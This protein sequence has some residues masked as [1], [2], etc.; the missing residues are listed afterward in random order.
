MSA[1]PT[2]LAL[3]PWL[4]STCSGFKIEPLGVFR[5]DGQARWPIT[6]QN[7]DD[8]HRQLVAGRFLAPLPKEPASLANVVEVAVVDFLVQQLQTISGATYARGSERGYPDL[9]ICG[10]A[11]GG[12]FH[13]VDVKVA[14]R[15]KNK[16][17]TQSA[18]TLYTGNT[19]FKYP[20]LHWPGTFRPFDEY[21]THVD[22]IAIY[23]FNEKLASR[24]ED[25]ELIV[26]EPWRIASKQRSSTTRE[27]LGAVKQIDRLKKGQGEF[28]SAAD[29]YRFWRKYPFKLSQ[30]VMN[31]Y[32]RLLG[33]SGTPRPP[34]STPAARSSPAP[35]KRA[36]PKKRAAR[37]RKAVQG[38]LDL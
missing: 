38:D 12:G 25:L 37:Q 19:Y 24:I 11:F 5:K 7:P 1:A 33:P 16:K 3:I 32:T 8:L 22:V 9:E 17:S 27:Y 13:A 20:T 14:R 18:I 31:T 30:A 29:F 2:T 10:S 35:A 15:A 21:T 6:A 34:A 4:Q 26:Q 36:A 28:S 23:T